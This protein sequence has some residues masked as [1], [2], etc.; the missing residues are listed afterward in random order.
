[1]RERQR[2]SRGAGPFR[3]GRVARQLRRWAGWRVI[4]G[5]CFFFGGLLLFLYADAALSIASHEKAIG[6]SVTFLPEWF[7]EIRSRTRSRRSSA[8]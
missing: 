7:R 1:M 5:S 2:S 8:R 3:R 4:G 6:A